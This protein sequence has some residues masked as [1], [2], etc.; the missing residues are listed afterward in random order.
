VFVLPSRGDCFPQAVAEAM[1]CGLPVVAS[2]VGAVSEMV[3][4]GFNGCLVP[5]RSPGALRAALRRLLREPQLRRAL[6][7]RSLELA[8]SRHDARRN[9]NAVFDLMLDG[10]RTRGRSG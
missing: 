9:C 1:A 5:P 4:D 8:R 6:G 10:A 3:R 2:D 7:A